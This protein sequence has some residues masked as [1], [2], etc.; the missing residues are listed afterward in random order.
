MR[1]LDAQYKASLL[2][3]QAENKRIQDEADLRI[4]KHLRGEEIRKPPGRP[5]A[6]LRS[7]QAKPFF[8]N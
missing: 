7:S 3:H 4:L 8:F 2:Q 1:K 5:S 6:N